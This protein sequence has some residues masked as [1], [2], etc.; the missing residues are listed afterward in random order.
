MDEEKKAG[1]SELAR[2]I[3]VANEVTAEAYSRWAGPMKHIEGIDYLFMEF[4]PLLSKAKPPTT[5]ILLL[6]AHASL[7]AA[8]RLALSGQLL[9]T[10]MALRGGLESALYA[11]AMAVENSLEAV[12]LNR[13]KD[14]QS[15]NACRNTFT[16]KKVLELLATAQDQAFS[17]RVREAYDATIDFGA[18]PNS[19]SLVASVHLEE[20]D[21]K[22]VAVTFGYIHDAQSPHLRQSLLACAE[23]GLL[24][25]YIAMISMQH[26]VDIPDLNARAVA[27]QDQLPQLA[28]ELGGAVGDRQ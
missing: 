7:R 5:A 2:F 26:R 14:V 19:Q 11:N 8:I 17:D 28:A 9:P 21:T 13:D 18:H 10:F 22:R 6:N 20:M 25:F 16:V 3:A 27:L 15:K 12:W 1:L 4:L 23:V 24:I